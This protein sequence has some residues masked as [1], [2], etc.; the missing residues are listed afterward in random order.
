MAN[1]G[2]NHSVLT[3]D[4][5][6]DITMNLQFPWGKKCFLAFNKHLHWNSFMRKIEWAFWN[7]DTQMRRNPLIYS[8]TPK[9]HIYRPGLLILIT[10]ECFFPYEKAFRLSHFTRILLEKLSFRWNSHDQKMLAYAVKYT[11]QIHAGSFFEI[12]LNARNTIR[13]NFT[14]ELRQND[15]AHTNKHARIFN[16]IV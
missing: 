1:S 9:H 15:P 10:F 7:S 13:G 8:N 14:I 5:K 11:L 12:S 3:W 6:M 4:G 16:N 2:F